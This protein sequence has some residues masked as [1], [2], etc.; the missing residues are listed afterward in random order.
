MSGNPT[1]ATITT[2]LEYIKEKR[3]V[4]YYQ[5]NQD[6]GFLYSTVKASVDFLEE[7]GDIEQI[8]VGKRRFIKYKR[9]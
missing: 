6:L 8:K 3:T 5:I 1:L 2:I 7:R 4:S 9:D